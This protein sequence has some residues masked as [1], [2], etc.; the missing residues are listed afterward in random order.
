MA[1]RSEI[2]ASESL[3]CYTTDADTAFLSW[4]SRSDLANAIDAITYW[5]GMRET[6]EQRLTIRQLTNSELDAQFHP[7]GDWELDT[8]L[9]DD[10][11]NNTD[12]HV[13]F[14]D[15]GATVRDVMQYIA[16]KCRLNWGYA[17]IERKSR[18]LGRGGRPAFAMH[19]RV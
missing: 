7:Q 17:C 3:F 15:A 6:G 19:W 10:D 9:E 2:L 12:T 13:M 8:E 4:S 14:F 5:V 18:H 1:A 11:G 16:V